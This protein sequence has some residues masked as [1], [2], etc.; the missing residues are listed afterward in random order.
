MQ[1]D[2]DALKA[3]FHPDEIDW[4]V[5]STTGDKSKGM[6]LA[7]ID[8]RAV[9][10]R[11]DASCGADKWQ[12][13]YPIA[14]DKTCC[15]IGILVSDQWVWKSDGAGDTDFEGAKGAFSDAFKRA[16]VRWGI[17]RYLYNVKAPW[18]EIE[19]M[20]KSFK[21]KTSELAKLA[22]LLPGAGKERGEARGSVGVHELK[23]RIGDFIDELQK[24]TDPLSF[25]GW[26][27]DNIELLDRCKEDLPG[28]WNTKPGSDVKGLADRIAAKRANL[29]L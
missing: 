21:I 16:A 14:N 2:L 10:D 20:G 9:M 17:G 18:V 11:L 12:C 26:L 19:P 23:K 24:Y 8:A 1:P 29:E 13:R 4:R 5:G 25:E 7:Y 22:T 15:E 28:W 3:P 6:A 27:G